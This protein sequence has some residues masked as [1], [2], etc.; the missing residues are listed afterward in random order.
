MKLKFIFVYSLFP[1][2]DG[3]KILRVSKIMNDDMVN[4]TKEV[5]LGFRRLEMLKGTTAQN[6]N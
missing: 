6:F 5:E 4:A 1:S 2:L 3:S